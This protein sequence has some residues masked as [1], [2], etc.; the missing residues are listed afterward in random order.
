MIETFWNLCLLHDIVSRDQMLREAVRVV[1][2]K[3]TILK[4]GSLDQAVQAEPEKLFRWMKEHVGDREL[5][6]FPGDRD[7]FYKL[8]QTGKDMDLMEYALQTIQHDRI[9]GSIMVHSGIMEQFFDM[10]SRQNYQSLLITEAEKY[11]KGMVETKCWA[12]PF[13]ITLL[14]ES[15]IMGRLFKTYFE[16]VTNVHVIQGSIYQPLPLDVKYEAILSMPN[17]G[18]KMSDDDVPI[19]ESEGA[20]VSHLLPLLHDGGRMSVTFPARMM[21]Q[22]GAIADWRKQTNELA[23]VQSV[24]V[25]PDGLFRPFTSIRTYQV[26]FG[27]SA[28]NEITLGR[29]K[30]EKAKLVTEREI[31]M[32]PDQFRILDNWRIDLLLDEDQETLRSFQQAAIPKVK[33]RDVADIFR[34][35]SIL[36][37]DLRA[38]SIKVLNISNLDDGE[39]L[40]DQLETIDEEERKVKRYEVLPGDLVMACR[41]TVNKMAVFPGSSDMVIASA[42]I[43]VIRFR[44]LIHS[45]YA[46]IFFESPIGIT[47]LQS[48][49]RGTTVMN[50]NPNDI[51]EIEIPLFSEEIQVSIANRYKQ[52][53]EMYIKSIQAATKRWKKERQK[54]YDELWKNNNI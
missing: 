12:R 2:T 28:V 30:V 39:V 13:T 33:L 26:E 10:C 29:W 8:Y 27:K 44:K 9:T 17:F 50:L 16:S 1:R 5:G 32:H 21:F 35:K 53:K 23:P 38:G 19:R 47:L 15:Y 37:Q 25:H 24:Y 42:N 31:T 34:G 7:L 40:L 14:T 18:M 43:L 41:G 4:Q 54:I 20:A 46:K 51:S 48:Y 3:Q 45:H 49:Q 22:S 11:V 6:H 36:K 52:E